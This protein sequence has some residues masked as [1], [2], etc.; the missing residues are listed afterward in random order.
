MNAKCKMH[1]AKLWSREKVSVTF[2][3]V[4]ANK[5]CHSE[6]RGILY[7]SKDSSLRSE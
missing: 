6:E 4:A 1:N 2:L 5:K 3:F 7:G